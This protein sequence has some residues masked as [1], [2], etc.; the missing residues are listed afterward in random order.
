MKEI[1]SYLMNIACFLTLCYLSLPKL[2][3]EGNADPV[4]TEAEESNV[5]REFDAIVE[6]LP[7]DMHLLINGRRIVNIDTGDLVNIY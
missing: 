6:Q 3:G 5:V 4:S 2:T 7:D 1:K